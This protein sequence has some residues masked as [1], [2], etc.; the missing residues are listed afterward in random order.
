MI[1]KIVSIKNYGKFKN[2][3]TSSKTWNGGL[4]HINVIY[5]PNG[6]GKTSLSVLFRSIKG[7]DDI[8]YKKKSFDSSSN[9]EVKF[10]MND[11]KELKFNNGWSRNYPYIEVFDS[12]Y[13]EENLY[14]ISIDDDPQKPNLFELAISDEIF[15]IKRQLINIKKQKS[16]ISRKITNRKTFL[17]NNSTSKS[18]KYD[19]D[20]K[21]KAFTLERNQLKKEI[22]RLN[23][24]RIHKT[25]DQRNKYVKSINKYLSLFCDDMKL[26]EIKIVPN[27]QAGIQ[28]LI[29]GL[30]LNGHNITIKDRNNASLKY[31]LSDGDKNALALSFFLA[32]MDMYPDLK[33]FIIV[34]DDPFTSFD[35]QRKTTTITQLCKLSRKVGQFILL[36]H[37][38]HFANDFCNASNSNI[39]TLKISHSKNGSV[40]LTHDLKFEMLT[41]FN[42]DIVT[43]R[44]YLDG[45]Y[46]D[47]SIHLRE[48]IRCIRPTIEGI[49]RIKYY[50]HVTDN[51]WLGDFIK[52]I[53]DADSSSP[54]YKIKDLLEEIEE[55]NDYSKIYHHS[56]PKYTEVDI[57]PIELKN[58]V[59]RT[60]KL[61]ESL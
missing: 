33:S 14:S 20:E 59:R 18:I 40:I 39:Q 3:N 35:S 12:F 45:K 27:S 11:Q 57:S 46:I 42:K 28:S 50:Y 38:C 43:L 6:S 60:L 7:N 26:S 53:R 2:F 34:V 8:V 36:T 31:Y 56:N 47:D 21:I 19:T 17:R 23:E 48:V 13:F 4:E 54:L 1:K 58:Y 32:R 61:I 30:E 24:E 9:P 41:G 10:I 15:E 37:D 16:L 52:M 22:L 55:I 5:A 44:N 49:F 29:Y 51:Q 25:E